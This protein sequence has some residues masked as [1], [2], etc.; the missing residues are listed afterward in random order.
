LRHPKT[1]LKARLSSGYF[2]KIEA[3]GLSLVVHF[4][5]TL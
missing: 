4:N 2:A 1:T 5:Y 3:P